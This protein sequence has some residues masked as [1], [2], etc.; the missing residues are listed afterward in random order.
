MSHN[1]GTYG[2]AVASRHTQGKVQD[3]PLPVRDAHDA[4]LGVILKFFVS[5]QHPL[6]ISSLLIL[7]PVATLTIVTVIPLLCATGLLHLCLF[8]AINQ[9]RSGN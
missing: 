6:R 2:V 7:P 4:G 5:E 8:S 9:K 1:S 3:E